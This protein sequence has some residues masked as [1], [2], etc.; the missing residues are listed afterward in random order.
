M[1]TLNNH[2][3]LTLIAVFA[4]N[5][6][7]LMWLLIDATVIQ[8]NISEYF[9]F[10][11]FLGVT[12]GALLIISIFA[13]TYKELGDTLIKKGFSSRFRFFF[14]LIISLL[15]FVLANIVLFV[16]H[17]N[18]KS[19]GN[20]FQLTLDIT[21]S[22]Y[23]TAL[24]VF[25]G[26]TSILMFFISNLERRSGNISTLFSQSMG[27]IIQ[28]RL[29]ERGFMFIDLNDSTSLAEQLGSEKYAHL[30]RDCFRMLSELVALSNFEIY[31]YVG[32][33]AVITW[34]AGHKDSDI[35]ALQLFSDYKAYLIEN[36]DVFVKAYKT[37]PKFKCAIHFGEV[38]VSEIGKDIK[39]LVYHGDVLNTTARLLDQCH[40]YKTDIIISQ[41]A[42][43]DK[44][45]LTPYYNLKLVNYDKL[46]GKELAV[47]AFIVSEK[48]KQENNTNN[49]NF[50]LEPKVTN[51]HLLTMNFKAMKTIKNVTM[52]T[53]LSIFLFGCGDDQKAEETESQQ[54]ENVATSEST[55]Q[56]I[57]KSDLELQTIKNGTV[58]NFVPITGRI[59]PKYTTQL[60]AEV[61]GRV[62]ASSKTFKAGTSFSKGQTIIRIDSREFALNLES[63]KSA[64]LNILIG[65]MP[66]LK[67]DYPENYRN[68]LNYVNGY[69][70]GK[71]LTALPA[72]LS[73]PEKYFVTS[74]QVY[75]TYY[76]IKAQEERLSKFTL[77][78]PYSGS[79]SM[80]MVDNGG[81]V[82]P[83][84][85]LGTFISDTN[86]EI[87]TAVKLDVAKSLRV[88]QKIEFSNK[89]LNKTF[90]ATVVRIN[91][92]VDPNTQN[93]PI[94]LSVKDNDL[95]SGMYLEGNVSSGNYDN[96]V[97]IPATAIN[98]DNSV[99]ILKD[100]VIK[101][102]PIE[103]KNSG[104]KNVVVSGLQDNEQLILTTFDNPISG[105]KIMQ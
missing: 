85:P 46:K 79:L 43:R 51:S 76:N 26:F 16:I 66:D 81:L 44:E 38:V 13:I 90:T 27:D 64:F 70:T 2:I 32:D 91:N 21:T 65:M 104:S 101:K 25:F 45:K 102:Q 77:R 52:L 35:K 17:F 89:A 8:N 83:G 6:Y 5:V 98:R 39:H 58:R 103:I 74:R 7:F 37:Q 54:Q 78:A 59:I 96:A 41:R 69:E 57:R 1:K 28:P 9:S 60:V 61:Q 80:A 95:R 31:Q 12:N 14:K 11:E 62:M 75:N 87:E 93:I 22:S 82:S 68:W 56:V 48:V 72:T 24:V 23:F 100:Y 53:L 88:G 18:L 19:V 99:H 47:S 10:Y 20:V 29:T 55:I 94:Y 92:I 15:L 105:L 84:Q 36:N 63:Q 50:F 33:E 42:I 67:A 86:Y 97:S 34:K 4:T 49:N 3:I 71:R 30:L 40:K 73:N